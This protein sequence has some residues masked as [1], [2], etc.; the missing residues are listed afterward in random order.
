MYKLQKVYC[1]CSLLISYYYKFL[2][3][4]CE[5]P[6]NNF[7]QR[8]YVNLTYMVKR[9]QEYILNIYYVKN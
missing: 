9:L 3:L 4:L 5:K 2:Y 8:A 1:L 7:V 6:K